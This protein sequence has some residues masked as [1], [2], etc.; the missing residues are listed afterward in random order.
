M[1]LK[2]RPPG[3]EMH[4]LDDAEC[5]LAVYQETTAI[6]DT[7]ELVSFADNKILS[8]IFWHKFIISA[9]VTQFE[10]YFKHIFQAAYTVRVLSMEQAAIIVNPL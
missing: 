8:D 2:P 5:I 3:V 1:A 9:L 10:V 7:K 4:D 6:A